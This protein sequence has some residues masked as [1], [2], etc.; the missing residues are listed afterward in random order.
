MGKWE[1]TG[2]VA[3]PPL[4]QRQAAAQAVLNAANVYNRAV[5]DAQGLGL[6]VNAGWRWQDG[7]GYY[8]LEPTITHTLALA[9]RSTWYAT[10]PRS[11]P[12]RPEAHETQPIGKLPQWFGL[13]LAAI[14]CLAG[15]GLIA[16]QVVTP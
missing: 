5:A 8:A 1:F 6:Y 16:Y 10:P 7:Q 4:D 11:Q 13:A 2:S 9:G 12:P 15:L 14:F 3:D